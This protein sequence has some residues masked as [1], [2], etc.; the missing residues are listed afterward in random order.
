MSVSCRRQAPEGIPQTPSSPLEPP[1]PP[2][3]SEASEPHSFLGFPRTAPPLAWASPIP[4]LTIL[5]CLPLGW[6]L[7]KG[8]KSDDHH[9]HSIVQHRDGH[10]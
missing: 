5:G 3:E 1:A 2:D 10:S 6:W 8:R 9:V 4:A 7:P